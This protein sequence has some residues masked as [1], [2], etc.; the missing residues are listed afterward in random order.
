MSQ[1]VLTP[2]L[3]IPDLLPRNDDVSIHEFLKYK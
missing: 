3:L 1:S 2:E